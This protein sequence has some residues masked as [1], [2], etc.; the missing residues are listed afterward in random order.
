MNRLIISLALATSIVIAEA[1][2]TQ[3]AL[4]Y[5]MDR[6]SGTARNISLGGAMGALGGDFSSILTNPAGIAVY[7]SSEFTFTPSLHFNH[8]EADFYDMTS[9]DDR[10]T[11]PFQQIGFIGTYK[12]MREA[13][14]GLISTHF[15][16]GYN[17]TNSYS[18][19]T[20]I[21]ATGLMSSLL[22]D[23][24]N[25]AN[26]GNWNDYYNGL[27]YDNFLIRNNPFEEYKGNHLHDFEYVSDDPENYNFGA[28]A[29]LNHSRAIKER[30]HMGEFNISLGANFNHNFYIGGSMG[31]ST[32]N[33]ENRMTHFE[34]VNGGWQ[35]LTDDYIY[36]RAAD[37]W[38]AREDFAFSESYNSSGVGIN[39][40]VGAIY[41]PTNS[42]R[43]GAAIHTPSFYSFDEEYKT[44]IESKFIKL[45]MEDGNAL[46]YEEGGTDYQEEPGEFSYNFRTPLKGI[47]SVAYTF[48]SYGLISMDYEYTDYSTMHY[49]SESSAIIEMQNINFQ[50]ELI[51]ETFRATH[52]LKF[53]AEFKPTEVLTLRAG[54]GI[55]QSPYKEGHFK[56]DDQHKTYSAGIGYR[57]NNMFIDFGYMMRQEKYGYS[58][59]SAAPYMPN[60]V[61]ETAQINSK[62]HQLAVTLG[63]RF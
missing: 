44:S 60:G 27:A 48:G 3:D 10:I 33:Y 43:I 38:E 12:P 20:F 1:Q 24:V 6:H 31:I 36:Y 50:N 19:N 59:Y 37:G 40:K 56:S 34:E 22:D 5:S 42:L 55:N 30:G 16:I 17:R 21:Q 14:T 32:L 7:R 2:S 18:R 53:G 46:I 25:E 23:F 11:I 8:S 41:K 51:K 15:G 26:Q 54:Y 49:K 9:S 4:R 61:L 45:G 52:N 28:A 35:N 29:G 47:G 62:Q 58:L 63:W 13:T 39:L 57:M